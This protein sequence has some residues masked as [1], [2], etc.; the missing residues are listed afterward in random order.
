MD[1]KGKWIQGA[2]PEAAKERRKKHGKSSL[3]C[4]YIEKERVTLSVRITDLRAQRPP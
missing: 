4:K 3:K 1:A 2:N